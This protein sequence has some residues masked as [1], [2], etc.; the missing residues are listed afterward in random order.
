MNKNV[1]QDLH[2][3]SIKE[4][5]GSYF[6]EYR[7]PMP[8][9]S[10]AT[11]RLT[12]TKT[13]AKN[14]ITAFMK[15][16]AET[17]LKRYPVP[18]MIFASDL[19][20]SFI[21]IN[22]DYFPLNAW[23]DPDTNQI[24]QSWKLEDL[25]RFCEAHS[26]QQNWAEIYQDIP[27]Q[28]QADIKAKSDLNVKKKRMQKRRLEIII[29]LWVIFIPTAWAIVQFFAPAWLAIITT[30]YGLWKIFQTWRRLFGYRK[31]SLVEKEKGEKESKKEHYYYHCEQNPEGFERLKLENFNNDARKQILAEQERIKSQNE[32]NDG[33]KSE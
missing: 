6:V 1:N 13:L 2:F 14:K 15:S 8:N 7:P 12:F 30:I 29:F 5:R 9:Y 32:I 21:Q 3:E 23:I 33:G 25:T 24:I 11:L 10:S 22:D 4:N 17:W 20:D 16:E 31:L 28:T 19:K 26:N 27:Y 18:L